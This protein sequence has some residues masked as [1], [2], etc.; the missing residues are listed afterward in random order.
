MKSRKVLSVIAV[1]FSATLV[2]GGAGAFDLRSLPGDLLKE[3]VQ[4]Q[5]TG[6]PAPAQES[7]VDSA[8]ESVT[9]STGTSPGGEGCDMVRGRTNTKI[10]KAS[11]QPDKMF[12]D[13]FIKKEDALR[14]YKEDGFTCEKS[15]EP[16][17]GYKISMVCHKK[18]SGPDKVYNFIEAGVY[19]KTDKMCD[20]PT[21]YCSGERNYH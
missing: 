15:R 14:I 9:P 12:N 10:G 7:A 13:M 19:C 18:Y 21:L 6:V 5:E 11:V 2:A 17:D 16:R 1:A 20:Q 3:Q 4:N 8:A